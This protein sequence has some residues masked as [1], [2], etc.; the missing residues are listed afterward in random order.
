M[1]QRRGVDR[2]VRRQGARG[3]RQGVRERR[4][5][6]DVIAAWNASIAAESNDDAND[7]DDDGW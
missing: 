3:R 1:K 5:K 7:D 4:W 6:I 2:S